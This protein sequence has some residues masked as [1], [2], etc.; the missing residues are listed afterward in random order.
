MWRVCALVCL[1][2]AGTMAADGV[3]SYRGHHVLSA[4]ATNDQQL[5]VLRNIQQNYQDLVFLRHPNLKMSTDMVVSPEEKGKLMD[6]LREAGITVTVQSSDLQADID[7]ERRES[8]DN[9]LRQSGRSNINGRFSPSHDAYYTLSEV[10]NIMNNFVASYPDLVT[11]KQMNRT[12]EQNRWPVYY[13]EIGTATDANGNTDKPVIFIEGLAHAR[14]WIVTASLIYTMDQMLSG[15]VSQDAAMVDAL[16]TFTWVIIPVVN[17]DGYDYAWNT[18]RLWRKNRK[19][20][21]NQCSGVDLNRNF[22]VDF[23]N[24]GVSFNCRDDTYPGSSPFSEAE[25]QN[26]AELFR[27]LKPRVVSF[28]SVHAYSQ[29][30]LYPWGYISSYNPSVV[31]GNLDK[32]VSV[33]Q[34]MKEALDSLGRVYSLGTAYSV[35]GY[36][37]SGAAEDW[38]L[39]EKPGIYAYCYELRPRYYSDGNF[40]IPPSN[41]VPNGQELLRSLLVLASSIAQEL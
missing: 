23:G 25:T 2:F 30:L 37:A 39:Q 27:Q 36:A 10:N 8:E 18:D 21:S 29:L 28:L 38:A 5:T 4:K 9:K 6:T 24:T 33:G 20:I 19:F 41:I 22:D 11:R 32:L 3:K 7:A 13:L 16:T 35:L 31:P 15:F 34:K 26:I 1:L 14:E 17:P 40:I 12:T